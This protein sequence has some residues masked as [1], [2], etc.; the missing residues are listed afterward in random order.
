[1]SSTLL[2][3]L[4]CYFLFF[5]QPSHL[6][7]LSMFFPPSFVITSTSYISS[8]YSFRFF[9]PLPSVFTLLISSSSHPFPPFFITTA[10]TSPF[11][12]LSFYSCGVF[13]PLFSHRMAAFLFFFY[14]LPYL[15]SLSPFTLFFLF[16]LFISP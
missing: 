7:F 4:V 1:M 16:A 8:F 9:S 15:I 5:F 6:L 2:S 10:P 12:L 11:P 14:Q 13:S 3:H